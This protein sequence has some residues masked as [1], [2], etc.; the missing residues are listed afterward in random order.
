M[1]AAVGS[2]ALVYAHALFGDLGNFTTALWA[3]MPIATIYLYIHTHYQKVNDISLERSLA[4]VG[5]PSLIEPT[6]NAIFNLTGLAQVNPNS[7]GQLLYH[8]WGSFVFT[9]PCCVTVTATKIPLVPPQPAWVFVKQRS[10]IVAR[11]ILP[12]WRHI[13]NA[14]NSRHI[15]ALAGAVFFMALPAWEN[16]KGTVTHGANLGD[17]AVSAM[18]SLASG[19]VGARVGAVYA[20]LRFLCIGNKNRPANGTHP[21]F[22]NVVS[23]VFLETFFGTVFGSVGSGADHLKRPLAIEA[24]PLFDVVAQRLSHALFR[25]VF[26]T[27]DLGRRQFDRFSALLA[28]NGIHNQPQ[29]KTPVDFIQLL[30]SRQHGKPTGVS[31]NTY[32]FGNSNGVTKLPRQGYYSTNVPS[33]RL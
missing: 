30:M 23:L 14:F 11:Y 8:I 9:V 6:G 3:T 32:L 21:F 33:S 1:F 17:L 5:Y 18:P 10:A 22:G 28:V 27:S 2:L 29:K 24:R 16:V 20:L 19:F 15:P 7:G 13:F 12:L 26:L 25:A 31:N 4:L